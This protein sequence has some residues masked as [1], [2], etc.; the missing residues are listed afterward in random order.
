MTHAHTPPA[1]PG[2][3]QA[4]E[5]SHAIIAR[6]PLFASLAEPHKSRILAGATL[7]TWPSGSV[8]FTRGDIASRILLVGSGF[9]ELRTLGAGP[10]DA[11]EAALQLRL[12]GPGE[13]AAGDELAWLAAGAVPGEARRQAAVVLGEPAEIVAIDSAA[14][15]AWLSVDAAARLH[16][17]HALTAHLA[18]LQSLAAE[19]AGFKNHGKIRLARYLDRLFGRM[20]QLRGGAIT[21]PHALSHG[22]LA[23]ALGLTRRS[24][25][26]DMLSLEE[27][28]AIDH[29]R[30]GRLTLRDR[31][32]LQ[33]IAHLGVAEDRDADAA[34]WREDAAQALA[35]GDTLR[36]FEL[37]REGLIYHPRDEELR[38]AAVLAA[39]RGGLLGQAESLI[40]AFRFDASASSEAVAA[41]VA[42]ALKERAFAALDCAGLRAAAACAARAYQEVH[43]RFGGTYSALNA[44]QLH[45]VAGETT[46]G[47]AM[48]RGL[49]RGGTGYWPLTTRAEALWLL[50]DDGAALTAAQA[51]RRAPDADEGKLATTRRQLRRLALALGRD[52]SPLLDALFV[53]PVVMASAADA[54]SPNLP[55]DEARMFMVFDG[56][57]DCGAW[58]QAESLEVVLPA[59]VASLPGGVSSGFSA[60]VGGA[61]CHVADAQPGPLTEARRLHARRLALGLALLCAAERETSVSCAGE[62]GWPHWGAADGMAEGQQ[63]VLW[64][65]GAGVP[66]SLPAQELYAA[67]DGAVLRFAM[68]GE[69]LAAALALSHQLSPGSLCLDIEPASTPLPQSRLAQIQPALTEAG[70][71]ATDAAAAEL[72]LLRRPDLRL[73]SIGRIRSRRRMNRLRLWAVRQAAGWA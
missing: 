11:A 34:S 51:A 66:A 62:T 41:L 24:V 60:L 72:A 4:R 8:L 20:G 27:F 25:L 67:E 35:Q 65:A 42:R 13:L 12:A 57:A 28:G 70:V 22:E 15:A 29:D 10:D 31:A 16:V 23:A 9:V 64:V 5:R 17:A 3:A 50:G 69:A 53:R 38:Y 52:A 48:A 18:A 71:F 56:P 7:A 63:I 19:L 58:A 26:D 61:P 44:A 37:A 40:A 49:V 68:P 55:G 14:L 30:A 47:L 39:L 59:P 54:R 43:A 46:T 2:P 36:G 45:C 32:R 33:R 1:R 6:A 73:Q 21:L